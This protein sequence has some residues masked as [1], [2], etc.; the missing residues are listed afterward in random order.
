[1]KFR[2]FILSLLIASVGCSSSSVKKENYPPQQIVS[3][4]FDWDDNIAFMPTHIY[5]FHKDSNQELQMSTSDFAIYREQVGKPGP[6]EDYKMNYDDQTGSF[7]EFRDSSETNYFVR[8]V[9][10][11]LN[12]PNNKWKGPSFEAFQKALSHPATSQFTTVITARGHSGTTIQMGIQEL[13][14]KGL[15]DSVPP[16]QN[17]YG[18]SHPRFKGQAD[19]PSEIKVKVMLNILDR[20]EKTKLPEESVAV[21][22][23]DGKSKT[24]LH[25]WGFSD[26]DYGNF[27][28][29]AK[30]LSQ[31]YAKG[32]WPHIKITLFFT[33]LHSPEKPKT[34]I[35]RPDGTLRDLM[36]DELVETNRILEP[37]ND[38]SSLRQ[39]LSP[40]A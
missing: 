26:D 40:A 10:K 23:A 34:K 20:I 31:E 5:L 24:P 15:V 38:L 12:Q 33:G 17:L 8:D 3:Y 37:Q 9:R 4:N 30:I 21:R 25:L 29:A 28:T 27:E 14:K 6:Y 11:L 7:R 39:N 1:M 2:V 19:S 36:N 35:I 18:V 22:S 13:K 16:A 32:R